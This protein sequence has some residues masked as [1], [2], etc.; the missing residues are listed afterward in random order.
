MFVRFIM[1]L[2]EAIINSFPLLCSIPFY[3]YSVE[4]VLVA[5]SCPTLCNPMDCS[6]KGSSVHRILQATILEWVDMPSSRGSSWPRDR[7]QVSSMADRLFTIWATR[8]AH[9]AAAAAKSLQSCPTLCDPTDSSSP[10]SAVPGILQARTLECVAIDF[11]G[12]AH[13]PHYL[14]YCW[15]A[16][17]LFPVWGLLLIVPLWSYLHIFL[18]VHMYVFLAIELLSHKARHLFYFSG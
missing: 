13:I 14:S 15:W 17:E 16:F 10:G 6:P 11:S 18:C 9:A 7:T 2:C 4:I 12:E 5:Q 1:L 3:E 8:E